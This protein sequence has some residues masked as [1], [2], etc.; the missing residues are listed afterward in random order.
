[1]FFFP[2]FQGCAP[3]SPGSDSS[4]ILET[5][6]LSSD[7]ENI[8]ATSVVDSASPRPNSPKRKKPQPASNDLRTSAMI[9][10]AYDMLVSCK[11]DDE[12]DAFGTMI[13]SNA[14]AW[15]AENMSFARRYKAALSSVNAQFELEAANLADTN[16]NTPQNRIPGTSTDFSSIPI[17]Y[18]T[19]PNAQNPQP[20]ESDST[21]STITLVR[22]VDE[23]GATLDI[24]SL[25]EL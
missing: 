6:N 5:Q 3:S 18:Y 17:E 25:S 22:F 9:K 7:N 14:R 10:N 12:W 4:S 23:F 24:N 13:A 21:N 8:D 1:M 19:D 11:P 16:S 15:S 2:F 20:N